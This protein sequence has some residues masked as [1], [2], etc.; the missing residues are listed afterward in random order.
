[1]GFFDD[2]VKQ[3][4]LL[5]YDSDCARTITVAGFKKEGTSIVLLWYSD[6]VPSD[7]LEWDLVDLTIQGVTFHDPVY[8]EMITGKVYELDQSGWKAEE[9]SVKFTKLPVWDNPVMIAE[10]SKT[11]LKPWVREIRVVDRSAIQR[12]DR[13]A[14]SDYR[15]LCIEPHS[16]IRMR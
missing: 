9:K 1:V 11:N 2:E 5:P 13:G 8:V 3:V 7:S 15:R 16:L 14:I 12:T 6:E 10:R 4:G